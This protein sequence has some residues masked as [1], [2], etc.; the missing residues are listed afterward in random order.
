MSKMVS[1]DQVLPSSARRQLVDFVNAFTRGRLI[2]EPNKTVRQLLKERVLEPYKTQLE[3]DWDLNYLS[4]VICW[5]I[6]RT[7]NINLLE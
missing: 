2:L 5:V 3:K 1:L 7:H 4:Y 6:Q